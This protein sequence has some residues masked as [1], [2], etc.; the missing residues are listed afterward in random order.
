MFLLSWIW[1][2]GMRGRFKLE[3]AATSHEIADWDGNFISNLCWRWFPVGSW[4]AFRQFPDS[5][6]LPLETIYWKWSAWKQTNKLFSTISG[7]WMEP[8]EF[9][10]TIFPC[11]LFSRFLCLRIWRRQL[12]KEE[13]HKDSSSDS[14]QNNNSNSPAQ[15]LE[16]LLAGELYVPVIINQFWNLKFVYCVPP[17]FENLEFCI[18]RIFRWMMSQDLNEYLILSTILFQNFLSFQ[19]GHNT[20]FDLIL[21]SSL[22]STFAPSFHVS[23]IIFLYILS[24]KLFLAKSTWCFLSWFRGKAD[25][26]KFLLLWR[27]N[28]AEIENNKVLKKENKKG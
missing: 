6:F 19:N 25:L 20:I 26:I 4:T 10:V 13:E 27:V 11:W 14:S 7:V 17:F 15:I 5:K 16:S 28:S 1:I 9:P 18:W 3:T 21:D 22:M 2:A 23:Q 24:E 8:V 12:R